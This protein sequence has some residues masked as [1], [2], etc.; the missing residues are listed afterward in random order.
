MPRK[1]TFP[2]IVHF[3]IAGA[4]TFLRMLTNVSIHKQDDLRTTTGISRCGN[5]YILIGAGHQ[6][7]D[8]EKDNRF[9]HLFVSHHFSCTHPLFPPPYIPSTIIGKV[10]IFHSSGKLFSNISIKSTAAK[11]LRCFY[12]SGRWDGSRSE[13]GKKAKN[14]L[15]AHSTC[16]QFTLRSLWIKSRVAAE[17]H[18]ISQCF[19]SSWSVLE[20]AA[21][22]QHVPA[23]TTGHFLTVELQILNKKLQTKDTVKVKN[24]EIEW[25]K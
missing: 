6:E 22:Y 3:L 23:E 12:H 13:T 9:I 5:K 2:N 18:W 16:L 19:L 20:W 17:A 10:K 24:H 1:W 8:E 7:I 15:L 21:I 11:P 25:M 4:I 14:P